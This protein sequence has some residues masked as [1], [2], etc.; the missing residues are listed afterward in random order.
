MSPSL[1]RRVR[2]L[3]RVHAARRRTRYLRR[4]LDE[5]SDQLHAQMRAIRARRQASRDH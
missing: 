5:I 1:K 2:A 4:E 3:E